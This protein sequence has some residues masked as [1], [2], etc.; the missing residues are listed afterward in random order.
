M[1][2]DD[3]RIVPTFLQQALSGVPITVYGSGRQTRSFCYISD[4]VDGLVRLSASG[5][6]YP[7]NLG[8]PQELSVLEFAHHIQRLTGTASEIVFEDLPEDD[9][10]RRRPD[11]A[12]ARR[13]LGWEPRVTLDEG[14]ERTVA[15]FRGLTS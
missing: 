14:L 5:E 4:L 15:Y 2:L 1:S 8:N 13:L 11:I 3:G 7:V 10:Q 9:P 12:K 6:A